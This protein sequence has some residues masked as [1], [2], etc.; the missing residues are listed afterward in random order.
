MRSGSV[1]RGGCTGYHLA[2]LWCEVMIHRMQKQCTKK[3]ALRLMCKQSLWVDL[4][5]ATKLSGEALEGKVR[6][7]NKHLLD[8]DK[9]MLVS[10]IKLHIAK[11]KKDKKVAI[12]TD[13]LATLQVFLKQK[14][15][16]KN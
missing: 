11:A 10:S 14:K 13:I 5:G 4:L 8:A 9:S 2:A 7:L 1:M 12:L 16:R 15:L 6:T 3:A